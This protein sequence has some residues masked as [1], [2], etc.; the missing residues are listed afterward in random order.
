[1]CTRVACGCATFAVVCRPFVGVRRAITVPQHYGRQA[2]SIV[3]LFR[4]S[5]LYDGPRAIR[6]RVVACFFCFLEFVARAHIRSASRL[7][8]F[9]LLVLGR[10]LFSLDT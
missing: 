8:V 9:S 2:H 5:P 7:Y 6:V 10:A 1:V 4:L 3:R